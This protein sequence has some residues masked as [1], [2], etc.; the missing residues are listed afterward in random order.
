MRPLFAIWVCVLLG[1]GLRDGFDDWIDAT[2]MPVIAVDTSVEVRDRNG[3]LLRAFPVEEG[4][5]RLGARPDQVDPRFLEMLIAYEDKRFYRHNGVDLLAGLRAAWQAVWNQTIVSGGSTLTM[6]AARLLENSGTGDVAGKLRQMRLAW[7]LERRLDKDE[8]LSVYLTNAPYGGNIEGLR[9]ATLTWFGKE[10]WRLTAA[11]AALLIALPQA[12]EKRRPDRFPD[13]ADAA[14]QHVI[15]RMIARGV[16]PE[17]TSLAEPVPARRRTLPMLAPHLADRLRYDDDLTRTHQLTL[18]A[19]LQAAVQA[20]ASKALHGRDPQMSIAVIVADHQSGEILASLGSANYTASQNNGFV[21]MSRAYRSPGSTL[22]P[23]VYGMGFDQG[24]IHPK[25]LID[26]RPVAFGTYAPQNFDGRFRGQIAVED[27]LKQ[28]LNI[29]VVLLT[30]DL[31]PAQL[32]AKLTVAG[33][34]ARRPGGSPGLAMA[35]GGLGVTLHDLVTLYAGLANAGQ[36]V[37]LSYHPSGQAGGRQVISRSAAWQVSHILS[38]IPPPAGAAQGHLAYKTG[39]SYGHRDAWAIGYDAKHVVGV[40]MG[41]PDGT[42]VPGAF[43]GDLAAP[44]LFD[45]FRLI[46]PELEAF[47]PPPPETLLLSQ[48]ALPAP[49]RVFQGRNAIFQEA[50]GPELVFPPNGARIGQ[51]GDGVTLKLR[52]GVPPFSVLANDRLVLQGQYARELHLPDIG[53][54]ASSISVL[55]AEGHADRVQ[56]WIGAPQLH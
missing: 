20:L 31:G 36:S 27:A 21:D 26:D 30:E 37:R 56:I 9:A 5:F 28:S 50:Q 8:I 43:G 42:P 11:Q 25:T 3:T 55:D 41:R 16:V 18:D 38:N 35:L 24:L 32:L 51:S 48:A 40:W 12:P 54:G 52:H 29:P 47:P 45:V 49:L 39:T 4:L 19:T 15:D 23:L 2:E 6:Q 1:A 22:K 33:V 7:A 13:T 46:K 53:I 10:P 17:A 14:R 44:V 34:D